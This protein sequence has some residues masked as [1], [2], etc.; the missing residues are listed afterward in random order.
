MRFEEEGLVGMFSEELPHGAPRCLVHLDIARRRVASYFICLI[1]MIM[2]G[3][4]SF[5]GF[6]CNI[7]QMFLMKLSNFSAKLPHT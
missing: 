4:P 5:E 3:R 2:L 1:G 6:K 7:Q